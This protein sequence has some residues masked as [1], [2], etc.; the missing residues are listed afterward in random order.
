MP[1]AGYIFRRDNRGLPAAFIGYN[2]VEIH[3][4]VTHDDVELGRRPVGV[5]DNRAD[6]VLDMIVIGGG[7]RNV[8]RKIGDGL[9]KV[10]SRHNADEPVPTYNRQALD[11]VP[12]EG[13]HNL[14]ERRIFCNGDRVPAS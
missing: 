12:L 8:P 2:A 14:F 1:D 13:P 11:V 7:V 5:L 10:G 9:K 6:F 4:T 3:N